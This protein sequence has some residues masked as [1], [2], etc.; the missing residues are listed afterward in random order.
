MSGAGSKITFTLRAILRPELPRSSTKAGP[1][2]VAAGV[3]PQH[4]FSRSSSKFLLQ[5]VCSSLLLRRSSGVSGGM[6]GLTC[7]VK[8]ED[9][10]GVAIAGIQTSGLMRSRERDRKLG[11]KWELTNWP[12]SR[13]ASD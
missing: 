9:C 2:L 3:D 11:V 8:G 7:V 13:S 5:Q 12:G 6:S 1:A 10:D 4:R